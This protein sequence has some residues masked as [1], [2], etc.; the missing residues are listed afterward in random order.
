MDNL[1]LCHAPCN[2]ILNDLPLAEKIRMRDEQREKRWM[3]AV[4]RRIAALLKA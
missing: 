4:R 3:R 1:A 2:R